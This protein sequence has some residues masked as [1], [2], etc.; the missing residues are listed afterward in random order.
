MPG[1][2]SKTISASGPIISAKSRLHSTMARFSSAMTTPLGMA[3]MSAL[4]LFMA[5]LRMWETH[6]P[7]SARPSRRA[8]ARARQSSYPQPPQLSS[9]SGRGLA[10]Q[11]Q[12][13]LEVG[14]ACGRRGQGPACTGVARSTAGARGAAGLPGEAV[15]DPEPLEG[16]AAGAGGLGPLTQPPSQASSSRKSPGRRRPGPCRASW[17][18]GMPEKAMKSTPAGRAPWRPPD[19]AAVHGV[20]GALPAR[21]PARRRP[22]PG[23]GRPGRCPASSNQ[24]RR[25]AKV[26]ATS[27]S[28]GLGV[29]L[30]LLGDAGAD[31]DDAHPVPVLA[32]QELAVGQERR[33]EA[34]HGG[35]APGWYLRMQ[36]TAVGQA[37]E[38]ASPPGSRARAAAQAAVTSWA[39][40]AVSDTPQKPSAL[41]AWIMAAGRHAR[42]LG[43]VG[44]RQGDH[45]QGRRLRRSR[46]RKRSS[47]TFLAPTGQTLTQV[48][49]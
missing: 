12:G 48:P 9:S 38:M 31:E 3:R 7:G 40:R 44:G 41:R 47:R 2:A 24:R 45:H 34:G 11:A 5:S 29:R 15:Q 25:S 10:H 30:Q 1:R 21:A 14:W 39:P 28:R 8:T 18:L 37:E 13:P 32:A 46:A 23:P 19:H 26:R 35:Q 22:P 6:M 43:D 27:R 20:E 33:E 17:R 36:S 42:E 49:Q 4:A 16:R